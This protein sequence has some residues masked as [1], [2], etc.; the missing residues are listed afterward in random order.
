MPPYHLRMPAVR[1]LAAAMLVLHGVV[2]YAQTAASGAPAQRIALVIG[3]AAYRNDPL[4]NPVNDAR[5][6]AKSLAQASFKVDLRENLD[7]RGLLE[8]IR[9]FGNRLNEDTIAVFYYA[10]HGLQL[11]DSNFLIPVDADIQSQEEIPVTGMNVGFLLDRMAGARSRV[12]IVILDACRNN[13]FAERTKSLP[14]GLAQMDAPLGTVL[15]Y[16]TGPG[17]LASDGTGGHGVYAQHLAQH[18]LT[19]G[20]PIETMFRR[21]REGVVRETRQQQIPW[22]STSLQGDFA[23]VPATTEPKTAASP[24][25]SLD[26]RPAPP[27]PLAPGG[28]PV[29]PMPRAGDTWRYRIRDQFRLGDLFVTARVEEVRAEGIAESWSSSAN[30]QT[31]S[32][33]VAPFEARIHSLPDWDITPPEFAPYLQARAPLRP[34]QQFSGVQRR[35]DDRVVTLAGSVTGEEEL[36]VPAGRFRA[37]KVVLRGQASAAA[38][39]GGRAPS[40]TAEYQIWYVPEIKRPGKV[41]VTTRVGTNQQEATTIE[42]M[43][44]KLQ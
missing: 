9:T 25:A 14:R 38:R 20:L 32:G 1:F 11:R 37:T 5:L 22:E 10:G 29:A 27:I 30:A 19:P 18:L 40:I 26:P 6:I 31:R 34:G 35:I 3:N 16:A 28:S 7:R 12:N 33:A 39:G 13:P 24:I 23:F 2:A 43:E 8:A 15:A 4:D 36:V 44:F 42:L 21:V 17:K 41:V